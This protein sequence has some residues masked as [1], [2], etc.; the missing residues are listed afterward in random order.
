MRRVKLGN[1]SQGRFHWPLPTP[2][3]ALLQP[4]QLPLDQGWG[5]IEDEPMD[6]MVTRR[7]VE[8]LEASRAAAEQALSSKSAAFDKAVTFGVSA[9]LSEAVAD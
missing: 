5:K 7:L 1:Q 2:V 4:S 6:R 9:N 3:R 8:S